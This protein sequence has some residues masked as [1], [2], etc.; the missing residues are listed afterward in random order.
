MLSFSKNPPKSPTIDRDAALVF[1]VN[2][3]SGRNDADTKRALIDAALTR[4]GRRG[5][6][7]PAPPEQLPQI[8]ADAA[9]SAQARG[10]AVVA[11][12]GDGTI[13]AV[14]AAAHRTG[15]PMGVLPQGTF[16]YFARTH[17][18]PTGHEESAEAL[19]GFEP[20]PVQVGTVNGR[21]FLVN[22]SLGLYPDLLEDREEFKQRFGRNRL[23][24]VLSALGTL[25]RP[26]RL[27]KLN[28]E[29]NG[30]SRQL[31]TLTLFIGN[32]RLQLANAGL[33]DEQQ[34]AAGRIS[35]VMLRPVGKAAMAWLLVR[36]AFARLG[37]ADDIETFDFERMVVASTARSGRRVKIA[38]DGELGRIEMPVTFEVSATPL[39]LLAPA[40]APVR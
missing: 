27:M 16:N 12:G 33:R 19:M 4:S 20:Q 5:E 21:V 14:A 39:W 32:N 2:A 23:I 24:A 34:V 29:C 38:I 35:A 36:G 1:I 15:C 26:H 25:V 3:A 28:V 13:N 10:T 9:A 22:A 40:G 31:Q 30:V 6:V 17:F 11:V 8:A 7:L 18:I 37:G